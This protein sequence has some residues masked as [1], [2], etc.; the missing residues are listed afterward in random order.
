V[1]RALRRIQVNPAW[2]AS[3]KST[4]C[5]HFLVRRFPYVIFYGE[6][7]DAVRIL[8]AAHAKRRPDYWRSRR[9]P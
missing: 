3:Y 7:E 2:G 6:L 1:E 4:E 5:R 8:A 9:V